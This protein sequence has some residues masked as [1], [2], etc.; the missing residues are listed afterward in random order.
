MVLPRW[1]GLNSSKFCKNSVDFSSVTDIIKA[2]H[3]LSCLKS[4]PGSYL[5][6]LSP[7]TATNFDSWSVVF[8]NIRKVV[9][10]PPT[11]SRKF[12]GL[13]VG[14]IVFLRQIHF[15]VPFASSSPPPDSV[16]LKSSKK[17]W[18]L[19]LSAPV[20]FLPK[21]PPVQEHSH[22]TCLT[23]FGNRFFPP[24]STPSRRGF[25]AKFSLRSFYFSLFSQTEFSLICLTS[26]KQR[27][28]CTL[29]VAVCLFISN[30]E[31]WPQNV[32]ETK[33]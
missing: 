14:C 24:N 7:A 33:K 3:Y 5:L 18:F 6:S 21:F 22:K 11:M 13:E 20:Y 32:V 10:V 8:S 28:V 23:D 31:R 16:S 19:V 30:T 12:D 9:T 4:L 29:H 27:L 17:N 25:R 1:R 15:L 2:M 26:V